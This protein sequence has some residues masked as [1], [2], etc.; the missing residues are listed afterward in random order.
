MDKQ[1]KWWE[2]TDEQ[3]FPYKDKDGIEGEQHNDW[4]HVYVKQNKI[5]ETKNHY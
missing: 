1:I 4:I 5:M 3:N 2:E